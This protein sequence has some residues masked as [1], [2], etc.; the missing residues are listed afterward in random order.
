[1]ASLAASLLFSSCA[2]LFSG[3]DIKAKIKEEVTVANAQEVTV[4]VRPDPA[5]PGASGTAVSVTRQKT[6][7]AFPISVSVNEDYAFT[8]WNS[9]GDGAVSFASAGSAST[10]ATLGASGSNVIIQASFAARPRVLSTDPR[11]DQDPVVRNK[12]ITVFFSED[13]VPASLTKSLF[14]VTSIGVG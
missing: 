4:T 8:G 7:V 13:I 10:T 11:S 2:N 3:E 12:S 6:G 5:M 14:T 1:M 9:V